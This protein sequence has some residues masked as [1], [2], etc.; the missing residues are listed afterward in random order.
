MTEALPPRGDKIAPSLNKTSAST[1]HSKRNSQNIAVVGAGLLGRLLS[2]RLLSAGHSVTLYERDSFENSRAAAFTAAGMISPMSEVV[3]ADRSIYEMGLHSMR[4]WQ[5]WLH[6][7]PQ[8]FS[9]AYQQQGSLVV[10]HPQDESEL[11]QFHQDLNYHLGTDNDARWLDQSEL[12]QLEP[13]LSNT[14]QRGL[15]LPREAHIDNRHFLNS[16]LTLLQQLGANLQA[17]ANVSLNDQA[18]CNEQALSPCDLIVDCRGIGLKPNN[19]HIRGVRGEV[20]RVESTE[21]QLARPV[22]LMHPRY[23]LYVVPRPNHQFILGAT[24]IES[25]DRSPVSIQSSLELSSALYTLSPAFAEA[26]IIEMDVNLRPSL[27][28]NLP[29][30]FQRKVNANQAS[31]IDVIELNGLFR[32]GYLLAPTM[33]EQALALIEQNGSIQPFSDQLLKKCP[34][35]NSSL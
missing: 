11:A 23:K 4:L 18:L 7:Y 30:I 24:E 5:E 8:H 9:G 1:A 20:L 3:V 28:D 26:R 27:P 6:Q 21:I 35:Q 33:V 10:A 15:F 32:H 12:K 22:R 14:L 16:S 19:P 34:T 17:N 25:E 13:D 29:A 2:W 31:A